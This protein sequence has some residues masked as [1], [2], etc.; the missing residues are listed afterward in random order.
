VRPELMLGGPRAPNSQDSVGLWVLPLPGGQPRQLGELAVTDATWSP[1]G[2]HIYYTRGEELYVAQSDGSASR[3]L[4][5]VHGV[6]FRPRVSPDGRLLRFSV[7][8]RRLGTRTLWE[9]RNDG[10]GLRE[11]LPG[12]N[13]SPFE[14]C[15]NWTPDGKYYVFQAQRTGTTGLW[16]LRTQL[17]FWEKVDREP[18]PLAVGQMNALSPMPG[19][20]GKKLFFL[21]AIPRGELVR[22]D[23]KTRQLAPYLAGLSAEGVVFSRDGQWV[24]YNSFPEGTLWRSKTDGS[25]RLQLTFKPLEVSLP[26][27]SPDGS[28]IAFAGR[29]PGQVWGIYILP[30]SGGTPERIAP[31]DFDTLDPTWSADGKSLIFG[32]LS[33]AIRGTKENAIFS[34]DLTTGQVNPLPGSAGMFSPRWSPDGRFLLAIAATF[35]KLLLYD[36]SRQKW[37]DLVV[38]GSPNY[39]NW[40]KDGQY[41]YFSDPFVPNLPAYRVRVSDRRVEHLVNLAD[42]GRLA[43]GRFG[44]WTGLAPDDSILAIRDISVQEI[45]ALNWDAP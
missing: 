19:K 22:Y 9:V 42:Y 20:D 1:D 44:W 16:A 39:P 11:L 25:E 32:R 41:V 34:V 26:A 5:S 6:P 15:G 8:D 13:P 38:Q 12:W 37:E 35:D 7:L 3:K 18:V 33:N 43:I 45:Y 14:C 21:G 28:R 40:S 27:W 4:V 10:S 2:S 29:T 24:A 23:P 30:A 36:F 17:H 31:M